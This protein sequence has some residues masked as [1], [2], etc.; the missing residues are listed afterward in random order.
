[1]KR[2]VALLL[3]IFITAALF[4][5]CSNGADETSSAPEAQSVQ[6]V[7]SRPDETP[8]SAEEPSVDPYEDGLPEMNYGDR[9][10]RILQRAEFKYE[11][12]NDEASPEK[13]NQLVAERNRNVED[14][15]GVKIVTVDQYGAWGKHEDFMNYIRNS[16]LNDDP[17]YDLIAGYAAIMPSAVGD[18]LFRNWYDLD[19]W[20]NFEKPWWSQDIVDE[21]SINNRL[22]L[23]TGDISMTFWDMMTCM[24][25]NKDLAVK[26]NLT[27]LY[28]TV[29]AHEWTFDRM[30]EI[31]KDTFQ[32]TDD[33]DSRIY[34]YCT[35]RTTQIDVYQDAFGINVTEKDSEGKPFFSINTTYGEK[36]ADTLDK[37]FDLVVDQQFT[38]VIPADKSAYEEFFGLGRSLFEPLS[39]GDGIKL[40]NYDIDYGILPM[41]MYDADQDAYYTA[42][43]DNYSVFAVPATTSDDALEFVGIITEALCVESSK[44]VIP[45][46]YNI[47]LKERN[48]TDADSVE[49]IDLVR[50]GVRCN[51][52][53]LYSYAMDWPA[54]QLNVCVN[55]QNSSFG[56]NWQ[57]KENMFENNLE[58]VIAYYFS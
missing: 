49:M 11:F 54:H 48:T 23:I 33:E 16:V 45:Q 12:E 38:Y 50:K 3:A 37:M 53:Y 19:E 8:E 14:R 44:T 6:P 40:K 52:G 30:L 15:F 34:S 20:I 13:V 41:P 55:A 29:R 46:Y 9:E 28:D 42:C 39:L 5:A 31:C 2:T 35:Q 1:M 24:F 32:P 17:G 25:F 4:A 7:E 56:T 26:Y 21:L 43:R 51:F 57:E 10:F 22:Y 18:D 27:D 47:V 58:N 36:I